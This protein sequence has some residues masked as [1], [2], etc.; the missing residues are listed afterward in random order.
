MMFAF[1][2][3]ASLNILQATRLSKNKI[4]H[5]ILTKVRILALSMHGLNNN[6]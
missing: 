4:L 2:H 6:T 5:Q 3:N 1:H